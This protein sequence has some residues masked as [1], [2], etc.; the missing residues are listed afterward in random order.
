[1]PIFAGPEKKVEA[2]SPAQDVAPS[3]RALQARQAATGLSYEAGAAALSPA[4]RKPEVMKKD[5]AD[6]SGPI[7][8]VF[9]RILGQ[10]DNAK[11][12]AAMAFDKDQLQ[13]YLDGHLKLAEGEWFRGKKLEGV[14]AKLMETLDTDKNGLVTWGEFQAFK[15]QVLESLAP[16]VGVGA[17]PED[18]E[19]AA[20]GRF[21]EM[22]GARGDGT[23]SFDELQRGTLAKLPK[24][25]D[26]ADLIAQLGARIALDA[27]DT[28]E[29][30][31]KV[32]D[33][34]LSRAEW[35]GAAK[36]LAR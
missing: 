13:R 29:R 26:H 32:K 11:G 7:G 31:K 12:T 23:L 18:V 25:T 10:S 15:D 3:A 9:N 19:K 16:G 5:E 36:E 2:R 4:D 20:G 17:K 21:D 27:V 30:S 33:R 8:R 6:V 34:G 1:M 24:D 28:D 35:T 22:D 14:A